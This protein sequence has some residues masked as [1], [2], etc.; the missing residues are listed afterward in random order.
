MTIKSKEKK[1]WD[2]LKV[3]YYLVEEKKNRSGGNYGK[4]V[5]F[6]KWRKK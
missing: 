4:A 2:L 3:K 5:T 1:E 6:K